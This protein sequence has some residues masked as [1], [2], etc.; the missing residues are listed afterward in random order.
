MASTTYQAGT[1]NH[2]HIASLFP[3]PI[4]AEFAFCRP[5]LDVRTFS[6]LPCCFFFSCA[7]FIVQSKHAHS[8]TPASC[9]MATTNSKDRL[10]VAVD[11]G[12]TYSGY[13]ASHDTVSAIAN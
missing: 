11:F 8:P 6:G 2:M 4:H 7:S 3:I 13:G 1:C 10:V 5:K 12:T 9:T